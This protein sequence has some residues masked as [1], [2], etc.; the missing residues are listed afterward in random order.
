ME[1][2]KIL[3]RAKEIPDYNYKDFLAIR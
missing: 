2:I 1:K 3:Y